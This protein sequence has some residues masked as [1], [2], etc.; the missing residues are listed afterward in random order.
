MPQ[1]GD[2]SPA[3]LHQAL[4][5]LAFVEDSVTPRV[6]GRLDPHALV[7]PPLD[8]GRAV[9][10]LHVVAHESDTTASRHARS[11]VLLGIRRQAP[12]LVAPTPVSF[13]DESSTPD[14]VHRINSKVVVVQSI[15]PPR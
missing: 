7:A 5:I 11:A 1:S 13:D 15:R 3:L 8:T 6:G 4:A 10:L 12:E 9:S 14:W 2:R